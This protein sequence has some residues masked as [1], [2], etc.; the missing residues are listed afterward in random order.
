MSQEELTR[1]GILGL[2][3]ELPE[4]ERHK[5]EECARKIRQLV[6]E[7]GDWGIL[8][9]TLIGAELQVKAAEAGF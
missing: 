6:E 7:Y 9:V 2:I 8:A 3:A 4:M 1:L 5:A